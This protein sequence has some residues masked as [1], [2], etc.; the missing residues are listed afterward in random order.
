MGIGTAQVLVRL[1][2]LSANND[3]AIATM[4]A[5]PGSV[6]FYRRFGFKFDCELPADDRGVYPFGLLR[7]SQSFIDD[8]RAELARRNITYPD[9]RDSIPRHRPVDPVAN[10]ERASAG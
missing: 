5:V 3:L 8:C 2:L 4:F 9:V 6:S 7:V 1:A 10:Q